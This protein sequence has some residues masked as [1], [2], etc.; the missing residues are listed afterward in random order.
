MNILQNP[1][2]DPSNPNYAP[3][4]MVVA[5]HLRSKKVRQ[6][7]KF[8]LSLLG[9]IVVLNLNIIGYKFFGVG[10]VF[11]PIILLLSLGIYF[12][13]GVSV[14]SGIPKIARLFGLSILFVV[15]VGVLSAIA[16]NISLPAIGLTAI[17]DVASVVVFFGT[18]AAVQS[19][20][21][22][23]GK[24]SERFV[25]KLCFWLS[26]LA[27]MSLFLPFVI[28]DWQRIVAP[29]K[30]P[31]RFSGLFGNPNEA[32][33]VCLSFMVCG[34]GRTA[35]DGKTR[36]IVLSTVLA[37][38]GIYLTGSRTGMASIFLVGIPVGLIVFNVKDILRF[39]FLALVL[40][41]IFSFLFQ[42]VSGRA[43]DKDD[44]LGRR[45]AAS[46]EILSGR[47]DDDST[48]G[49]L[50]LAEV[51]WQQFMK[52][53]LIGTGISSSR[54]MPAIHAET[55]NYYLQVLVETG[56]MGFIPFIIIWSFV[57]L[58]VMRLKSQHWKRI[59]VIGIFLA[60]SFFAIGSHTIFTRRNMVF[61]LA[62][63]IGVLSSSQRKH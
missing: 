26:F 37:A 6:P 22:K 31:N 42:T 44:R 38:I 56:L 40:G 61:I 52:S 33:M 9:V 49:R 62:C 30:N 12:F 27:T 10:Q 19:M 35:F 50:Y 3:P 18:I 60:I 55:H 53:P 29:T 5:P 14:I 39:G 34:L 28:P 58:G 23:G 63:A 46:L 13:S 8:W 59:L 43:S 2:Y 16:S 57:G 54:P 47:V 17:N 48:G 45:Y 15:M 20:V 41:V 32:S 36:W 11:S 51:A 1:G 21:K 7:L 4:I 24:Q 25:L